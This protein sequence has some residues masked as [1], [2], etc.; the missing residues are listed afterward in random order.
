MNIDTCWR[1][2]AGTIEPFSRHRGDI[3]PLSPA[4]QAFENLCQRVLALHGVDCLEAIAFPVL[5]STT[6]ATA[7][8]VPA[9]YNSKKVQSMRDG[10]RL[11]RSSTT[12]PIDVRRICRIVCAVP[13]HQ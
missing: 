7:A 1:F 13:A 10:Q 8:V 2:M 3:V 12:P 6:S 4:P 11:M 9:D 5:A